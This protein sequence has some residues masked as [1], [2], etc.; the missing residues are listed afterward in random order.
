MPVMKTYYLDP[1]SAVG[2]GYANRD[3]STVDI[4]LLNK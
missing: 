2:E 4:G 3:A 1:T